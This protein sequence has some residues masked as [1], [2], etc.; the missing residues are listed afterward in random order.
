MRYLGENS[1][2]H[3]EQQSGEFCETWS[4]PRHWSGFLRSLAAARAHWERS[5]SWFSSEKQLI[6]WKVPMIRLI[7][8]SCARLSDISSSYKEKAY[9]IIV[10]LLIEECFERPETCTHRQR[11]RGWQKEW[12]YRR[13]HPERSIEWIQPGSSLPAGKAAEGAQ[14]IQL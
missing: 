8:A 14:P 12:H 4:T 7:A 11:F 1:C 9:N 2:Y 5:G 3:K 6:C 13:G 10:T